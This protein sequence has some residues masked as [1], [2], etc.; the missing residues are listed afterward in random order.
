[1]FR[2]FHEARVLDI[3]TEEL[4]YMCYMFLLDIEVIHKS[5]INASQYHLCL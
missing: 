5:V 1:M 3:M 4:I 2:P